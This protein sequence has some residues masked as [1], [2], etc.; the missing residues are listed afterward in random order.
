MKTI[1]AKHYW[2]VKIL[3]LYYITLFNANND[4]SLYLYQIDGMCL[5]QAHNLMVHLIVSS[6]CK[7]N[8]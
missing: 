3:G 4:Q 6:V 7:D 5:R 8:T 1:M 2:A